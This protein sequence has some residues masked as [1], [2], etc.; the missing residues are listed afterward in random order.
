MGVAEKEEAGG[1]EVKMNLK[2]ILIINENIQD[3]TQPLITQLTNELIM[4]RK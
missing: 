3:R 4:I 1:G 2:T